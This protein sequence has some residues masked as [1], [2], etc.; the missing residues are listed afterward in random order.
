MELVVLGEAIAKAAEE[1]AE[2]Q[3]LANVV[4]LGGTRLRQDKDRERDRAL[5]GLWLNALSA[6]K[7]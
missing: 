3:A 4:D 1:R 2:R 5:L 7:V 6:W